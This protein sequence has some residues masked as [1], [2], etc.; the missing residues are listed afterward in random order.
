VTWTRYRLHVN[1]G[2][3]ATLSHDVLTVH[4]MNFIVYM[5]LSSTVPMI[6]NSHGTVCYLVTSTCQEVQ[7]LCS[8]SQV[9]IPWCIW[10]LM[11]NANLLSH[12]II[13]VNADLLGD[14]KLR[15]KNYLHRRS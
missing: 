4:W 12:T 11:Q 10:R 5:L 1:G 2:K 7:L 14:R 3:S 9:N 6:H 13:Y 15:Y 8:A